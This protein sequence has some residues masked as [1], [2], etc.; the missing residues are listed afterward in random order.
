[1]DLPY[2]LRRVVLE[3]YVQEQTIGV[4]LTGRSQGREVSILLPAAVRAGNIQL[5]RECLLVVL[6]KST[7]EIHSGPGNASFQAWLAKINFKGV[8][9]SCK[10]GF[11]AL[12]SLRFPFFS[13]FCSRINND[14]VLC[15]RSQNLR[16]L[17][18]KFYSEEL[19]LGQTSTAL[20]SFYELDGLLELSNLE[21]LNFSCHAL[22]RDM[23]HLRELIA[24]FKAQFELQGRARPVVVELNHVQI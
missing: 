19:E 7:F 20:R 8:E 14:I 17:S 18:I 3:L 1:M 9:T 13:H 6:L 22:E 11:D 5:R 21:K 10:T 24:W 15:E 23:R 2:D 16:K 12:T 4:F